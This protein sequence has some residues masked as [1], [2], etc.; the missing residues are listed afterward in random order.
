MKKIAIYVLSLNYGGAE[1]AITD[2]AN[3]LSES[4]QVTINSI[5]KIN[6]KSFY[7]LNSSI[8]VNYLT[9]LKPNREEF[10]IAFKKFKFLQAFKIGLKSLKILHFKKSVIIK[11]LKKETSEIVITTRKEHNYYA[12]KYLPKS[13]I[14]IGQEHNDFYDKRNIKAV[15]KGAKQLNYFM[16][17]SKYLK[18]KYEFLLKEYSVKVKYIPLCVNEHK[19]KNIKKE[20]QFLAVGR[21][22]KVKGFDDLIEVFAIINKQIP[23]IKL[24]IAGNGSEYQ[25]LV[26]KTKKLNLDTNIIFKGTV[27]TDELNLEYEKSK[28]LICTSHSESFGLVAIEA[29]NAGTATIAFDS[30]NGLKEILEK[31][32][33]LIKNRSKEEMALTIIKMYKENQFEEYGKI[34]K[35]NVAKY[36]YDNVKKEWNKFINNINRKEGLK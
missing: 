23:D 8:K 2:I 14:K 13:V 27:S 25:N 9:D 10:K 36:Y 19:L 26:N 4:N 20:N 30:A 5:Y 33:I 34:A 17:S 18:E 29:A 21:L 12:G 15:I 32:G 22:E 31:P 1:K 3:I 7:N 6:T 28:I 11:S 24:I 16:P 35:D